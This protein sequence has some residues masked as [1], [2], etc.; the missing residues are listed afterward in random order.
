MTCDV[1]LP[2]TKSPLQLYAERLLRLQKL[3]AE[4]LYGPGAAVVSPT[5]W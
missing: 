4:A 5:Y 1:G 2:S 3:A